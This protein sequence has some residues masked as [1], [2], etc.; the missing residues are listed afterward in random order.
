[1]VTTRNENEDQL[2]VMKNVQQ[3]MLNAL[4]VQKMELSAW[5]ALTDMFQ[6]ETE[7]L[8]LLTLR[9]VSKWVQT[10]KYVINVIY[11][12][13]LMELNAQCVWIIV[14]IVLRLSAKSVLQDSYLNMINNLVFQNLLGAVSHLRYKAGLQLRTNYQTMVQNT[15]V[16]NVLM[17]GH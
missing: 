15:P 14:Y 8:V 12:I 4:F 2:V 9:I 10:E 5:H 11:S 17:V 7:T 6:M 3:S 1:M 16:L 13:I